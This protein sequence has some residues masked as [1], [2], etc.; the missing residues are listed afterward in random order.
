MTKVA[1]VGLGYVGVPLLLALLKTDVDVVGY[2]ISGPIVDELNAGGCHLPLW[3]QRVMREV[4]PG[5][6]VTFS[7]SPVV[8][9]EADAIIICV[10]TPLDSEGKPDHS[11][12]EAVFAATAEHGNPKLVILESTVAPGFTRRAGEAYF[13]D[14]LVTN[15]GTLSLCFSPE[16]EDPGNEQFSNVEIPKVIGGLTQKCLQLGAELYMN[17]FK[18]VVKASALEAAELCKVH[19]NTFRAVNISYVNQMRNLSAELGIDFEEVINLAN[20]KP[21]GF[22][23]FVSGIGV[24]GHC[25]P[26]D[27]HYLLEV[28]NDK[29]VD[30]SMVTAAM[31]EIEE[32]PVSTSNWVAD[33]AEGREVLIT[34][35]AY[36]DGVS[37][38]RCSPALDVI[39]N[40][41]ET[42][43]VSYWDPNVPDLKMNNKSLKS[44]S[45][46][47]FKEF[48][49]TVVVINNSGKKF[50]D[51]EPL[52][53][54][55]VLDARYRLVISKPR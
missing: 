9:K 24:G 49:G 6:N 8:L 16:R 22:M 47:Q 28:A 39:S 38:T 33:N 53:A 23:A 42:F 19:E 44:L 11:K 37:D 35:A 41:A 2:D 40:L 26:I 4:T 27:P 12:V 36:K 10:P 21:F 20:S 46:S 55:S 30:F 51:H 3:K 17:V 43:E 34:G 32:G 7:S 29:K 50:V 25:I 15:G 18:H 13:G 14:K 1:V 45:D 52:R 54:A 5:E 31:K 48:T